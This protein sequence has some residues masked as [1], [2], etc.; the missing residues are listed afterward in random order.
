M[1]NLPQLI[2][3][4]PVTLVFILLIIIVLKAIWF[5][6]TKGNASFRERWRSYRSSFPVIDTGVYSNPIVADNMKTYSKH[7]DEAEIV[8]KNPKLF[9]HND[10]AISNEIDK[11]INY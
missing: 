11:N 1:I 4:I 9:K 6:L 5:F 10:K 7:Q 3:L 2:P 8:R